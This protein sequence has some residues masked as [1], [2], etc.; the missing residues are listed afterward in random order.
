MATVLED[1]KQTIW[2]RIQIFAAA[3]S[4]AGVAISPAIMGGLL[5]KSYRKIMAK[6]RLKVVNIA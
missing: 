1:M 4:A 6:I 5:G 3:V 2:S